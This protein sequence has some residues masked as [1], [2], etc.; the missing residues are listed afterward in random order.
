MGPRLFSRGNGAL[1][2]EAGTDGVCFNGAATLQSRKFAAVDLD[3]LI[4][5]MLQWGRD[6]SVA[7]IAPPAFEVHLP[8]LASMGPRLFSRGNP[9]MRGAKEK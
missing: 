9:T 2:G 6:S 7:E 5:V 4:L 8:E 3:D 1:G